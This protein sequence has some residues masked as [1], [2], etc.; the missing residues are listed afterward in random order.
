MITYN[1]ILAVVQPDTTEQPALCRAVEIA[2]KTGATIDAILVVYDHSYDMTTMLTR[3]EREAMRQAVI[4]ER[5]EWLT[6]HFT[7]F[8]KNDINLHVVWSDTRY[9][10]IIAFAIKN[11]IDIVIKAT[12]NHNDLTSVIFTPTDWHLLR[13][14]PM[15]ILL[16]KEHAWP[17]HGN[18]VATVNVGTEDKTHALLNDKVTTIAKDYA[19]LLS[20][21]VHLVNAFP[22]TPLNIAIEIPDFNP[23]TYYDSVRNHHLQNMEAHSAKFGISMTNCH[24]M[25]G[26]PENVV[27]QVTKNLDAELVVIGTVGR[28]GLSAAFIGNTAEQVI[29]NINCDVLAIKPDGFVS[30]VH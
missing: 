25:E 14:C 27:K 22:S 2:G 11:D 6:T 4:K 9:E 15:P 29:D 17:E 20:G 26:L 5:E 18:I 8:E 13:K 21:Q 28:T 19:D 30:P 10:A 3:A 23:E 24:V 1:R 12:R 16:V 7:K